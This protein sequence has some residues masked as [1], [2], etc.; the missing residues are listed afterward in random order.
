MGLVPDFNVKRR[1]LLAALA[2]WRGVFGPATTT[3]P[4]SAYRTRRA[5]RPRTWL[6]CK[7][8]HRAARRGSLG[9]GCYR[10]RAQAEAGCNAGIGVGC[11]AGPEVEGHKADRR[12]TSP[13]PKRVVRRDP[14]PVDGQAL[15]VFVRGGAELPDGTTAGIGDQ[16]ALRA[17]RAH[18]LVERGAAD[19]ATKIVEKDEG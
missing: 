18:H 19:Y 5:D 10:P 9:T 3:T 14:F 11:I 12:S 16:V 6:R 4:A 1:D 17:E 13:R 8:R 7:I 2:R 15:V